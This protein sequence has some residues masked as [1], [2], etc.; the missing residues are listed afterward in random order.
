M[1]NG[2]SVSYEAKPLHMEL[3]S[4]HKD[5]GIDKLSRDVIRMP[6]FTIPFRVY[7]SRYDWCYIRMFN[8]LSVYSHCGLQQQ[9]WFSQRQS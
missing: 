1:A 4:S 9:I 7:L 6:G 5:S 2:G 3:A 8:E